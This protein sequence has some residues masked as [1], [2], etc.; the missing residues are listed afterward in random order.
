MKTKKLF[1][2]AD[3]LSLSNTSWAKQSFTMAEILISLTIIGVIAA[4]TLPALRANIN[5]KTWAT[6]KKA[7]FSRMSQ[8]VALLDSVNSYTDAQSFIT[9]GL[10]EVLKI[11]NIC[12]FE[13]LNDCGVDTKQLITTAGSARTFPL[14]WYTLATVTNFGSFYNDSTSFMTTNNTDLAGAFETVNGES[15]VVYYNPNCIP[16]GEDSPILEEDEQP[17]LFKYVCANLI[18]DLNQDKG[19]NTVGKDIGFMTIFY[20]TDPVVASVVPSTTAKQAISSDAENSC[21]DDY[22]IPNIEEAAS[23]QLNWSILGGGNAYQGMLTS[24]RAVNGNDTYVYKVS[25]KPDL[26]RI[27]DTATTGYTRCVKR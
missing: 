6:Q 24:S 5:E 17:N 19:P 10:N 1:T 8:A 21:K 18:Y 25:A 27:S 22:R 3:R 11:N 16:N 9:N 13:S 4:I 2:M 7:L 26:K 14:N 12:A 20:A 15:V 23:M